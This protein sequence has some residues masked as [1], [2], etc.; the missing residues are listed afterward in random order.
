MYFCRRKKKAAVAADSNPSVPTGSVLLPPW[1]CLKLFQVV[2]G[3]LASSEGRIGIQKMLAALAVF[4]GQCAFQV[5][6][7]LATGVASDGGRLVS[8]LDEDG[9]DVSPPC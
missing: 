2:G 8:V 1:L 7:Y 9:I 6:H 4:I 5:Q 3:D